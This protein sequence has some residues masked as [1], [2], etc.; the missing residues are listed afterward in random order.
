MSID[1]Y[2]KQNEV[3]KTWAYNVRKQLKQSAAHFVHGKA[4]TV[5]R[6]SKLGSIRD[7]DKL[8]DSIK[9]RL[10]NKYGITEGVSFRFE[11]HGVFVHK[12][13]GKGY[14]MSGG[15]VVRVAKGFPNP[16]MRTPDDWFNIV[17]DHNT[18]ELADKIATINADA[19]VNALRLRIV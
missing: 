14:R 7:E 17:V 9:H 12:G 10:L 6:K 13:V 15:M 5:K 19:V 1:D 16:R 3:V 11:R 2:N 18:P 8:I 4:G